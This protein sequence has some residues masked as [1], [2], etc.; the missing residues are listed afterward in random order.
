MREFPLRP[1][2]QQHVHRTDRVPGGDVHPA[3]D[4]RRLVH[5]DRALRRVHPLPL[6]S[7]PLPPL[8]LPRP[9]DPGARWGPGGGLGRRPR[10]A[11]TDRAAR[12]RRS[13][14]ARSVREGRHREPVAARRRR[15]VPAQVDG[16]GHALGVPAGRRARH[17]AVRVVAARGEVLD[18]CSGIGKGRE[19]VGGEGVVLGRHNDHGVDGGGDRVSPEFAHGRLDARLV[20]RSA[21]NPLEQA[22]RPASEGEGSWIRQHLLPGDRKST[23]LNSSHT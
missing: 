23:R 13:G 7:L 10:V 9:G 1:V 2:Q 21:L 16:T 6:G 8:R 15:G 5:H 3:V 20:G 14:D 12:L 17:G 22:P 19:P 4:P 18:R 11:G